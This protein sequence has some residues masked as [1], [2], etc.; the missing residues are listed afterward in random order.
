MG[1]NRNGR[2]DRGAAVRYAQKAI[3]DSL[4]RQRGEGFSLQGSFGKRNGA[5]SKPRELPLDL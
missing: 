4:F 2:L 1:G 5:F 3:Q